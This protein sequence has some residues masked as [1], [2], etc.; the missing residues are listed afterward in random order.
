VLKFKKTKTMK[1][2]GLA[3]IAAMLFTFSTNAQN[4][5]DLIQFGLKA[6]VNFAT[7]SGDD[8]ENAES[9]TGF[10]AGGL[11][12]IPFTDRFSVQPEILYSQQG[13]KA[14]NSFGE[15]T[16][17]LDYIQIPV[18]AKI[19]LTDGFNLQVGP[20]VGFR[21]SENFELE[22]GSNEVEVDSEIEDNDIDFSLAGGLGYKFDNGFFIQAR[23][24]YAFTEA[25]PNSDAKNSVIQAGVGYL[26]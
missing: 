25:F 20:Q 23:Y 2:S 16:W 9:R 22:S 4:N 17:K 6:G 26:F 15:G 10:H 5:T 7:L 11:V 24:N 18:M 14:D 13:A 3:F 19:Y 21:M 1:K 12:E 8:V